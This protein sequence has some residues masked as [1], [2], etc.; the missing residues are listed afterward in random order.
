MESRPASPARIRVM[1][2]RQVDTLQPAIRIIT[3]LA[4]NLAML[5]RQIRYESSAALPDVAPR[6]APRPTRLARSSRLCAGRVNSC[7]ASIRAPGVPSAGSCRREP[8]P[9]SSASGFGYP[10]QTPSARA[11]SVRKRA[12]IVASAST[13]R[14]RNPGSVP[15]GELGTDTGPPGGDALEQP[16]RIAPSPLRFGRRQAQ[17]TGQHARGKAGRGRGRARQTID[18]LAQTKRGNAEGEAIDRRAGQQP[19]GKQCGRIASAAASP[20]EGG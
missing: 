4:G 15:A 18:R 13:G 8:N 20:L 2:G 10:G 17:S 3:P 12:S 19:L 14:R 9:S 7:S 1:V 11:E 5:R 16:P 6:S